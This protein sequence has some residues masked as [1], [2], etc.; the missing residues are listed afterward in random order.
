M[1]MKV[2]LIIYCYRAHE[3][4]ESLKGSYGEANCFLLRMN[5][6]PPGAA[7]T[8]HLPDPWSQFINNNIESS[9]YKPTP[10]S[11][12]YTTRAIFDSTQ[13]N[14]TKTNLNYHPLSPDTEELIMVNISFF[15]VVLIHTFFL[16]HFNY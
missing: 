11:S 14:D 2:H 6:R 7:S 9:D 3:A 8:E 1:L 5:S 15:Y 10:E 4:Y 16:E 13:D 12:P